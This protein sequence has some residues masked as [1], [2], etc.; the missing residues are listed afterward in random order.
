MNY[1]SKFFR[2]K[3]TSYWIARKTRSTEGCSKLTSPETKKSRR[4]QP[5]HQ[6]T[7]KSQG[8]WDR[9][10]CPEDLRVLLHISTFQF[11]D[12]LSIMRIL[13]PK[14]AYSPFCD[15]PNI[16][17]WAVPCQNLQ[18]GQIF[19]FVL[20]CSKNIFMVYM[21]I[22]WNIRVM[23]RWFTEIWRHIHKWYEFHVKILPEFS[24]LA[25]IYRL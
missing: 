14:Y 24:L 3:N 15:N 2:F 22:I 23:C 20:F 25:L 21:T 4:D 19:R 6:N 7:Y 13:Y 10:M 17:K 11:L 16:I 8:Q 18:L 12:L 9:T 1:I 5:Q